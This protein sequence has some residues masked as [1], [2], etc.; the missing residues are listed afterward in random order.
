MSS[1]IRPAAPSAA[2]VTLAS[3]G[4]TYRPALFRPSPNG[5]LSWI[6]FDTSTYPCAPTVWVH[7][8][9]HA[10]L[11]GAPS[12]TGHFALVPLSRSGPPVGTYLGEEVGPAGGRAARV[13]AVH[14]ADRQVRK[15]R[16]LDRELLASSRSSLHLG[17]R[18]RKI[19]ART[20]PVNRSRPR[21]AGL[22]RCTSV[23]PR[24][25][26]AGHAAPRRA[27]PTAPSWAR[28]T[29]TG[30]L[31]DTIRLVPSG[32]SLVGPASRRS[33]GTTGG[34]PVPPEPDTLNR[35]VDQ[36]AGAV[37]PRHCRD[38]AAKNRAR[39]RSRSVPVVSTAGT[40][41]GLGMRGEWVQVTACAGCS[42]WNVTPSAAARVRPTRPPARA[43]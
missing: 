21:R 39:P 9:G 2:A 15:G 3:D 5:S 22:A 36:D 10:T 29:W 17:I 23:P 35:A 27:P 11:I 31:P 43:C 7:P 4:T 42:T 16:L 41:G 25:A 32:W 6:A 26:R 28:R 8:V 40:A 33:S 1:G 37:R 19:S 24:R 13:R 30:P 20:L 12:P 18:P 14:D 38:V 34:T